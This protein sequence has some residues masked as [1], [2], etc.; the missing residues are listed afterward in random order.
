M[1]TISQQSVIFFDGVCNLCNSTVQLI[2]KKDTKNVFYFAS[3]QSDAAKNI[4]LQY[5]E[6]KIELNSIVFISNDKI[7]IKSSAVLRIF[8]SLGR[9][10]RLLYI[11]WIVPKPIRNLVYDY[12][13]TNRYKW[14]GKRDQCMLP[15]PEIKKRFLE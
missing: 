3:L 4:L 6:E 2:I 14:F 15:S 12:I 11:F 9:G 13:A 7:Y 10:Y 8:W 1:K 5:S